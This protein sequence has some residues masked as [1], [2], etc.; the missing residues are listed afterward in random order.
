[1]VQSGIEPCE[2]NFD[3]FITHLRMLVETVPEYKYSEGNQNDK[4]AHSQND[5]GQGNEKS[6]IGF[7]YNNNAENNINH[8]GNKSCDLYKL[9]KSEDSSAWKI[10]N[11]KYFNLKNYYKGKVS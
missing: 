11:T 2:I 8:N 1:M 3:K 9:F 6:K 4:R 10:H 7:N 5:N